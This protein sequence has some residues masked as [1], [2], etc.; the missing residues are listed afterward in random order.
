KNDIPTLPE[1]FLNESYCHLY[2]NPIIIFHNGKTNQV[3]GEIICE[4]IYICDP[5]T[6][7]P[8]G[9]KIKKSAAEAWEIVPDEVKIAGIVSDKVDYHENFYSEV[10]EKFLRGNQDRNSGFVLEK[11]FGAKDE[12]PSSLLLLLQLKEFQ[13]S[14]V[15]INMAQKW[16]LLNR[17]C[18]EDSIYEHYNQKAEMLFSIKE[19]NEICY[20]VRKLLELKAISELRQVLKTTS[21]LNKD[22]PYNHEKHY[23]ADLTDYKDPNKPLQK[24]HLKSWFN[25]NIWSLVIDHGLQNVI[26]IETVSHIQEKKL[27]EG[28][29]MSQESVEVAKKFEETKLLADGYKLRKAIHSIL[30]CL[31]KKVHFEETRIRT[32]SCQHA[33]LGSQIAI[34]HLNS[35]KGYVSILKRVK[36]LEI[37][38]TTEK[39]R[40][41]IKFWQKIVLD[42]VETVNMKTQNDKKFLQELIAIG[43]EISLSIV[44]LPWSCDTI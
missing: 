27:E 2:Y 28:T 37:L 31:S 20:I 16:F 12:S 32:M 36:L 30:L 40:N 11:M 38:A 18:V 33:S 15:K 26:E 35:P 42:Y 14:Y 29:Y 17:K 44:I 34:L 41:L 39:I 43:T 9:K 13:E 6:K 23:D 10:F 7:L 25:I 4:S 1:D 3:K 24:Q 21:F 5:I 22:E 19:W 8:T